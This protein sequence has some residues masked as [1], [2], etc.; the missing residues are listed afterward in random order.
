MTFILTMVTKRVNCTPLPEGWSSKTGVVIRRSSV[1]CLHVRELGRQPRRCRGKTMNR[2][3]R[4]SLV[5]AV[6]LLAAMSCQ[7][8]R[9]LA[10]E[11]ADILDKGQCEWE[12][13]VA[14]ETAS[15]NPARRAWAIQLG[16]GFGHASQ[17]ALAYSGAK[18]GGISGRSMAL[19]GKT[20][21]IER[22]D[23]SLGL[24]LAWTLAG[25]KAAGKSFEHELTQLNLVAT[26]EIAEDL[27][28]HA[29][30]GWVRSESA[31][32]SSTTW[33]LAAELALAAGVDVTGELY[34]DDRRKPWYGLG[35]RWSTSERF[36]LNA[37][38]STQTETPR[39]KLWTIGFKLGF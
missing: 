27:T 34:G 11:D 25:E 3:E 2:A 30:L 15:G 6:L 38:Y 35:V 1:Q 12:G 7:A 39:V 17:V 20:G 10:T 8:G 28:A 32:S 23:D 5:A 31:G 14:R 16:C 13:F 4:S 26:K 19:V 21:L 9:P 24:T 37:S 36:S 33:N 18:S 22:K 29:N